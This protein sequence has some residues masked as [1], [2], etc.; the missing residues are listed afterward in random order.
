MVD[1]TEI[2]RVLQPGV[3]TLLLVFDPKTNGEVE[4]RLPKNTSHTLY[5]AEKQV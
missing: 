1:L 3:F 2:C 4:T 5:V